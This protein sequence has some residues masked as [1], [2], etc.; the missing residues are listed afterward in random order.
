MVS[1]EPRVTANEVPIS[2]GI[3]IWP[4][5]ACKIIANNPRS[6]YPQPTKLRFTGGASGSSHRKALTGGG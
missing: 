4:H 6:S 3:N 2:Y 5:L 1:S